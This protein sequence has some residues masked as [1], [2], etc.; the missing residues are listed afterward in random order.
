MIFLIELL[1]PGN[2]N[3]QLLKLLV[4]KELE[5]REKHLILILM[6]ILPMKDFINCLTR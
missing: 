5:T 6:I 1:M 4:E 2:L 3:I